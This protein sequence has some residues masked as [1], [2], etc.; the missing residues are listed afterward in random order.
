MYNQKI[1][2]NIVKNKQTNWSRFAIANLCTN[3][4]NIYR[5]TFTGSLTMITYNTSNKMSILK[6]FINNPLL[7]IRTNEPSTTSIPLADK[8]LTLQAK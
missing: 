7:I 4:R 6:P 5:F 3:E 2:H 1:F 8:D